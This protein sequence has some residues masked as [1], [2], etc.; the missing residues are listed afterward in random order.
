[1]F[2][3]GFTLEHREANGQRVRLRRGGEGPP[4][5]LLH[6]NPQT[7]AMWHQRGAGAGAALHRGRARHP[8]LRL[9]LLAAGRARPR[10]LRQAGDGEGPGR[11]D[12]GARLRAL[13]GGEPRPRRARGAPPGAGPPGAG[14]AALHHGHHPDAGA[15]RARRHGLRHGLLPLVLA[16]AAARQ[17]G[18]HDPPRRGGLVRHPHH[19]RAEGPRLLPPRG[20]RRL[21]R[22]AARAGH[23]RLHLRGLPRG[24][25]DRPGARPRQPRR[26]REDPVPA[27][28]AVGREGRDPEV[29][30]RARHLARLRRP[31]R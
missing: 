25:D 6:G 31:G 12:G 20:P 1:M 7:H 10:R 28:G 27:A 29:V 24:G 21:P 3:E 17:A 26:R 16:G 2:F 22:G 14:G 13:P 9:L 11:A 8:R 18:A 30:R 19:P 5:L 4:L 23:R 15:F